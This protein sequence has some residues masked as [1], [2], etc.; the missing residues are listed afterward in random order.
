MT[1]RRRVVLFRLASVLFASAVFAVGVWLMPSLDRRGE[2]LPDY[3]EV[4]FFDPTREG[5]HL[6]PGLD[7]WMQGG[8]RDARARI[9][10]NSKGF[11]NRK[12][13]D[14]AVPP[15]TFRILFLG[16]SF[17]DG[18]R[19]DQDD[20]IGAVLERWLSE[21]A[22][23]T[24]WSSFEVMISGH[25]NPA[26]AWYCF[27]EHGRKY[28]AQLVILG[29]TLGNDLTWQGYGRWM[30]PVA[31]AEGRT[32]LR[33]DE[34]GREIARALYGVFLPPDSFEEESGWELLPRAEMKLRRFLS[35]RFGFA[36]HWVPMR[37]AP[38]WSVPRSVHA[39]D[40][41]LSLGLFH[42]PTMP[43]AEGWYRDFDEVLEGLRREVEDARGRLLVV[44]F[45]LPIQVDARV[46]E[47]TKRAYA[48]REAAFD[49][50][51]PDLRIAEMC[52]KEGIALL[53]LLAL[54]RDRARAGEGPLFRPRGDMHFD[55]QGQELAAE[56]IGE[57]LLETVL[58]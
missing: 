49:L 40:F 27:Q 8:R 53:D 16:D 23:Q 7:E 10:T 38:W 4:Y 28:A 57:H 33:Y 30:K 25:N 13:F 34:S 12:E 22:A 29:V 5:G 32:G 14:Y 17:V 43:E 6:L 54:F 42:R 19:T 46:W 18:M 51:D 31:R 44:L 52:R 20:T 41:T 45:P 47:L 15:G 21:R 50:D 39:A 26:D 1:R 35:D 9:V 56:A 2:A 3:G 36:G 11:R 37:T 58:R 24:P 55:E 48:L